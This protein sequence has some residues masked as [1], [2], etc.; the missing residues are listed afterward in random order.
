MGE[1][2]RFVFG[3]ERDEQ[4]MKELCAGFGISRAPPYPSRVPEPDYGSGMEVRSVFPRGQG[5]KVLP[6]CPV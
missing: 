3:Y 4:T 6:I 2:L 1:Q 5:K